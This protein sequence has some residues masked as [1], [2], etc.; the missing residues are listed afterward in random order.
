MAVRL[1]TAAPGNGG[2]NVKQHIRRGWACLSAACAAALGAQAAYGEPGV[3]T[4]GSNHTWLWLVIL[5]AA[6]AVIVALVV[7]TAVGRKKSTEEKDG[8]EQ[9][10]R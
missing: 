6:L 9:K 1:K 4:G 8:T 3:P 7:V 2:L 10:K 5:G